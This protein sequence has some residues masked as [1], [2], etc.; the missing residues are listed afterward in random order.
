M[1]HF[2]V[3]NG[4]ADGI[5]ALLQLQLD[6][7]TPSKKITGVKR[8]IALLK[9]VNANS[10]DTV[11][12]L[13]ISMEKNASALVALLEQ[14]VGVVYIDHHKTGAIPN[15]E[16]LEQ[17][18]D[19]DANTC[20][21]LIVSDLLNQKFHTWAVAAAYGDNLFARAD[22]EA[23]SLGLD[24]EQ[25]NF[26]KE[27]GTYV[28]YNGYGS[29]VDD[30]HYHPQALFELLYQYPDPFA[31][32]QDQNSVFYLLKAAY[33]TDMALAKSANVIFE[34]DVAKVIELDD[35]AWARRISGVY[36][37]M[38]ANSA[39]DRAHAVLSTNADGGY[40][41]SVRA[42]LNNKQGASDVCS[43]FPT[44]GGREAAAGI[45]HLEKSHLKAFIDALITKYK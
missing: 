34:S 3:F 33:E 2:D 29:E 12:V 42:P 43:Q 17:H 13:D 5:I 8:D 28:N 9:Q 41:V 4:D 25:R 35:A 19:L 30:L 20:T 32:Q 37:N 45:N 38:L 7:P 31:L 18:I 26:L 11:R 16:Y 21:S 15:S 24:I 27:L 22:R 36:G 40:T 1:A 14:K 44:G 6:N 10:G 23:E 39:P